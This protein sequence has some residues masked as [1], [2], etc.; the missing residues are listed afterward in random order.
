MRVLL[1]HSRYLS[2][3]ASGENRVLE[4]E[5]RLL[6]DAGHDV[7]VW[8]PEPDTGSALANARTAGSAI[9]SRRAAR[10][11]GT[12]VRRS[13]VDVVHVHNLFPTLSP[14]VLK[15]ARSEGAAVV[16][17]LHNYRLMCLPANFLRDGRPCEDCLGHLPWP[18]VVHRC[19]RDSALGSTT[20]A[21]SLGVARSAG[22]FDAV[23][24][25]LAVSEFVRAKHIQGGIAPERIA[26]K[27]NFTWPAER[28]T[29]PGEYLLFL[30]RLSS[31]KGVDTILRAADRSPRGC[32]VLVVG[33]GPDAEAL[34]RSAPAN[35]AFRG[36]VGASEVPSILA[37]A[38]ALLVPSRWYEAAPRSIIEAY[39]AGVPVIASDIGA[40][41]EAVPD[42][43]TGLLARAD[44]PAGWAAR[45]EDLADDATSER[46][47]EGAY[48]LWTERFSPE[49]G[50]RDLEEAYSEAM[51][52]R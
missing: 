42:G 23:T 40:L 41:P 6:Q 43:R 46:L 36:Q 33:D 2:G 8:S 48:R 39:A 22:A 12:L 26:V 15:A 20:L 49:R 17:T 4:E 21:A 50:V 7:T 51:A 3:A 31:E 37:S 32:P 44:D 19:Y 10:H 25:F 5:S 24:R 14:A 45:M 11:V 29:G 28:R 9:W 52:A 18:G 13:A 27:P 38:R 16:M 30:G 35:V 47:G 1:L 34:R